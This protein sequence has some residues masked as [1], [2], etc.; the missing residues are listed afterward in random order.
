[1]HK[2][3]ICMVTCRIRRLYYNALRFILNVSL[4]HKKSSREAQ[5]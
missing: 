3:A 5:K 1:M 2:Y 4:T